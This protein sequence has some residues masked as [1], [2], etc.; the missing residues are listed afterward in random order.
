MASILQEGVASIDIAFNGKEVDNISQVIMVDGFALPAINQFHTVVQNIVAREQIAFSEP[1]YKISKLNEACDD[2]M[3]NKRIKFTDKFWDPVDIHIPVE[4][5]FKDLKNTFFAWALK[6][7]M[8]R[9]DLTATDVVTFILETLRNGVLHDAQRIAWFAD[10]DVE[11][12]ADGGKLKAGESV[13]DYNHYDGFWK[14]IFDI[15]SALPS[16]YVEI[17]QN[18]AVTAQLQN[19]LAA[20]AAYGYF[21]KMLEAADS[22][23]LAKTGEAFIMTTRR[24]YL[25]YRKTLRSKNVDRSFYYLENGVEKVGFDGIP[26]YYYD[27]WDQGILDFFDG[28]V[29]DL[30]NRALLTTKENLQIGVDSISGIGEFRSG[31]DIKSNSVIIR[32]QYMADAKAMQPHM[33]VAA[34]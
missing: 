14:Q 19:T 5:C 7:G 26:I 6:K 2:T 34:Y 24:M 1:L 23:L 31:Y 13:T 22:R 27:V 8:N 12:E 33:F 32:G 17:T 16:Q 9:S 3:L 21:E 11:L 20:D 29:Y 10:L 15:M 25:N 28:T 4:Q 30:P 18:D